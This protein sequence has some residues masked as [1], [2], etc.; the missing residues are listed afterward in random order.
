MMGLIQIQHALDQADVSQSI[1]R[2]AAHE[3]VQGVEGAGQGDLAAVGLV[4]CAGAPG[5]LFA[6][7]RFA[8]GL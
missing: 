4:G 1:P 5:D 6:L 7:G 3:A 2:C 8:P